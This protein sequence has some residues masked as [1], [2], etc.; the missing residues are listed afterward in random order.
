MQKS[1]ESLA[2]SNPEL[3]D[4]ISKLDLDPIKYKLM[5]KDEGEGKGWDREKVDLVEEQYKRFLYMSATH[6]K[7]SIVPTKDIDEFWHYHILDTRKYAED[8]QNTFGFF[9]HHFPYLGLRGEEDVKLLHI[10]FKDTQEKYKRMF[11]ETYGSNSTDCQNCGDCGSTCGVGT[12]RSEIRPTLTPRI[13][14]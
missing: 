10:S 12:T 4:K 1:L 14:G 9:V 11:G 6:S 7:S 5:H 2:L 13:A 3:M 8:C